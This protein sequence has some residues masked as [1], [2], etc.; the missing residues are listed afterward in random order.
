MRANLQ[1]LKNLNFFYAREVIM[2]RF[3]L[4]MFMLVGALAVF[5]VSGNAQVTRRY[6]ASIPFDF[7]VGKKHLKAGD[8]V[9]GP[10]GTLENGAFLLLTERSTGRAQLIGQTSFKQNEIGLTGKM[11]FVSTDDGW[12]LRSI[13][14]GTFTAQFGRKNS[15]DSKV[16]SNSNTSGAKTIAIQ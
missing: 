1:A 3:I 13:E 16:A 9:V 10:V 2:K 4:T 7:S 6:S 12:V 11:Q 14:T 15:D 8:Y 5:S